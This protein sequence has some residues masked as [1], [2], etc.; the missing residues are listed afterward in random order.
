MN[1]KRLTAIAAMTVLIASACQSAKPVLGFATA[2]YVDGQ[3][4]AA[5]ESNDADV[6]AINV[7][8]DEYRG[9]ID[10]L[11][12]L[13]ADVDAYLADAKT[14]KDKVA[15][16]EGLADLVESRL[17]SMPRETIAAIVEILQQHLD[18]STATP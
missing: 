16:L 17:E 1:R 13:L 8:L 5:K 15:Q 10:R 18:G 7:K 4:A 6:Q 9:K 11:D 3:L 2:A 14:T 12:A